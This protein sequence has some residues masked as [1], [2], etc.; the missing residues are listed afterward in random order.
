[1]GATEGENSI[2]RPI[3]QLHRKAVWLSPPTILAYTYYT[4]VN[5]RVAILKKSF[6]VTHELLLRF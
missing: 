1:M 6:K 4:Q 3:Y 5:C 2:L